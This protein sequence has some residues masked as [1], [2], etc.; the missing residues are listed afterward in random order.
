MVTFTF[1]LSTQEAEAGG[2]LNSRPTWSTQGVP[3]PK[4]YTETLSQ[5]NKT[6]N[7]SWRDGLVIKSTGCPP[8]DLGSISSAHVV[9]HNHL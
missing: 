8:E 9:T 7:K 4:C 3:R 5:K 1:N 2:S 6:N